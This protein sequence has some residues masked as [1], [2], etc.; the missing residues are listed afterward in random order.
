MD[1]PG[2]SVS[3][4]RLFQRVVNLCELLNESELTKDE[5]TSNY[6]F[7]PRQ[8][9]YYTDAGRY[10]GLIEKRRENGQIIFSLTDEGRR[11]LKL[12]YKAEAIKACRINPV[13]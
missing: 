3:T 7:D 5:I 12:K 4:G 2:N 1:G 13:S 8:T 6:D 10:L 11:L 9:N